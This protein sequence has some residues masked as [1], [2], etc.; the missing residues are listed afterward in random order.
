M[1]HRK[2]EGAEIMEVSYKK[3]WKKMI[4]R[5][6]KKGDIRKVV[7]SGTMNKLNHNKLVS[8][9]VLLQLCALLKCNIGDIV[10]VIM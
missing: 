1:P 8:M 3:L 9:A 5:D 2:S 7:S 4:D 6:M 10:D